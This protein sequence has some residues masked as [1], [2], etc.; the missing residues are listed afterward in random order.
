M[1]FN[2]LQISQFFNLY[3]IMYIMSM[4]LPVHSV[5]HFTAVLKASF[6]MCIFISMS[7]APQKSKKI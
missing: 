7:T 1:I 4:T 6:I 5:I 3:C 2:F